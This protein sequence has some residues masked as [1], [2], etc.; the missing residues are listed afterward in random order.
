MGTGPGATA[1]WVQAAGQAN[2][3]R[4]MSIGAALMSMF[5]PMLE[6]GARVLLAIASG[7]LALVALRI[8]ARAICQGQAGVFLLG[9]ALGIVGVCGALIGFAS[10]ALYGSPPMLQGV[11]NPMSGLGFWGVVRACEAPIALAVGSGVLIALCLRRGRGV[12]A[13]AA[14]SRDREARSRRIGEVGEARVAAELKRIGLPSL[15]NVILRGAGWSVELDHVVRVPSGIVVLETKTFGGTIEG[16]LDSPAWTQRT[17]GGVEL[18]ELANP[19]LQNQAHVWAL[20]GFLGD[21]RVP[22]CGY[23]VSA[24]RARFAPE[25]MDAVVLVRDLRWVLSIPFAEPNPRVLD[26]AWRRLEREAAKSPGRRATHEAY[27]RRRDAFQ[28]RS[29]A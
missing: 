25:I 16:Q 22:I 13:A 3:R 11:P 26:A 12:G 24:G 6:I 21:L 19:V 28:A 23:V 1:P 9:W 20:E 14:S 18:G 5:R 2:R 29:Q 17:A 4:V 8:R 15:H 7:L 27:A 10:L